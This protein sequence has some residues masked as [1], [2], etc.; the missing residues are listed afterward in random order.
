MAKGKKVQ[1]NQNT[2]REMLLFKQATDLISKGKFS[3]AIVILDKLVSQNKKHADAYNTLGVAYFRLQKLDKALEMYKKAVDIN[4]ENPIYLNNYGTTLSGLGDNVTA[5]KIIGE[6]IK[7]DINY[8]EAYNNMGIALMR[9]GDIQNSLQCFKKTLQL[10]PNHTRAMNSMAMALRKDNRHDEAIEIF[11][12]LL[13]KEPEN[14]HIYNNIGITLIQLGKYDDAA[15]FF[16]ES[17]KLDPNNPDVYNNLAD[18]FH[19]QGKFK[20]ALEAYKLAETLN[21]SENAI[22]WNIGLI[23]LCLGDLQHGWDYFEWGYKDV[24]VRVSIDFK[25]PSWD[26]TPTTT[27]KVIILA[28]QGLGDEILFASCFRDFLRDV[29]H[30]YINCDQRLLPILKRSFPEANYVGGRKISDVLEL[31]P[32]LP[33]VD[34]QVFAGSLPKYYRKSINDF[35]TEKS[36]LL[37]DPE[38]VKTWKEYLDA[39]PGKLKVGLT[40]RSGM[41]TVA[42]S[43]HYTR[44]SQWLDILSIPNI[45]FVSLQYDETSQREI[46][47]LKELHNIEIIQP[48]NIDLKNDIDSLAA[49]LSSLDLVIGAGT[50]TLSLAGALGIDTWKLTACFEW[51]LLGT[52]YFPW[53]PSYKCFIQT[54]PPVW[55]KELSDIEHNLKHKVESL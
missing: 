53:H 51:T 46:A 26:G 28:E 9:I 31:N 7:R 8:T 47:E 40:W 32:A 45:D 41:L 25:K 1:L 50:A 37:A 3:D 15:Q 52:N 17:L 22:K 10:N 54:S 5:V 27:D 38:K 6:A 55:T 20:A 4:P 23:Y 12:V 2:N 11:K 24:D 44:L 48:D 18:V 49:L 33:V 14:S 19:K 39:Y 16:V 34:Y 42:R 21:P 13:D 29:E 35:P 36:Y 30:A 43:L